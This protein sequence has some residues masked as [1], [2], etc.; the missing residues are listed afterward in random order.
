MNFA[1]FDYY[2][3]QWIERI[4]KIKQILATFATVLGLVNSASAGPVLTDLT[5]SDYITINSLDWAWA[6]PINS[7][8]WGSNVLSQAGLH[9][10]WREATDSEWATHPVQNDFGGK[11]ASQYWNSGYTHCDFSDS[12]SQHWM[13][14]N[15]GDSADLLYVRGDVAGNNVPEPTSLALVGAALLGLVASRKRKSA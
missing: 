7:E 1:L 2:Q 9:A 3:H 15:S 11:C 12:L 14:G 4:V 8:F 10:G 5:A 6:A 13:V